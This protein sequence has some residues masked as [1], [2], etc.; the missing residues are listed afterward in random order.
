LS[1]D[2]GSVPHFADE[3]NPSGTPVRVGASAHARF[4]ALPSGKPQLTFSGPDGVALAP[5]TRPGHDSAGG[6]PGRRLASAATGS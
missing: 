5:L 6:E 1:P 3:V 4:A 2:V